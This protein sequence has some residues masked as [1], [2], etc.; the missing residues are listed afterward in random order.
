VTY[1]DTACPAPGKFLV[2]DERRA[3]AT[4]K[5][6]SNCFQEAD[7][8][9]DIDDEFELCRTYSKRGKTVHRTKR[10]ADEEL[11]HQN[12]TSVDSEKHKVLSEMDF[13]EFERDVL[14]GGA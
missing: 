1:V 3:F 14:G 7:S 9:D 12:N 8:V 5:L 13:D 11:T 2:I 10:D 6:C 4:A